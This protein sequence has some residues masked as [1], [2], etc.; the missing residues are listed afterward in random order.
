MASGDVI[1][2]IQEFES[3]TFANLKTAIQ[4][5]I[6]AGQAAGTPMAF[7]GGNWTYVAGDP[8]PYKCIFAYQTVEP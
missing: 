8:T 7:V 2:L 4:A 3:D 6:D 5:W 1:T